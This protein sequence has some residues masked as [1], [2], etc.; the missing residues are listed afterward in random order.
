MTATQ[1]AINPVILSLT[2]PKGYDSSRSYKIIDL[3]DEAMCIDFNYGNDFVLFN[4]S[5]ANQRVY[6][7]ILHNGVRIT[8]D[9]LS[10]QGRVS[11]SE[12]RFDQNAG[13]LSSNNQTDTRDLEQVIKN[14]TKSLDEIKSN[15]TPIAGTFDYSLSSNYL[16][17]N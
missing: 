7:S 16:L 11:K 6:R 1:T 3:I 8:L 12:I 2:F 9:Y 10:I 14:V 13:I 5:R 17:S 15:L 4:D